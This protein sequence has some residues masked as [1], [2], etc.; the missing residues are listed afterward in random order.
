MWLVGMMGSGKTTAGRL[1]AERL[2][3]PFLDIDD[4]VAAGRGS[5]LPELWD[6][7][8]EK[9]FRELESA[10]IERVAGAEAIVSTGGGVVLD[11]ANRYRMKST[12]TV[13]WLKAPPPVLAARL[14]A[15]GGRPLLDDHPDQA[16]RLAMLLEE[17]SRAYG[18]AADYEID[19]SQL[20]VEDVAMRIVGLW[21]P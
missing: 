16:N 3:V 6:E 7:L 2:A 14:E 18:D 13:V 9:G 21:M 15:G 4:E 20:S 5:S 1:A 17:R 11:R 10:A 12:G 19:T 8:G